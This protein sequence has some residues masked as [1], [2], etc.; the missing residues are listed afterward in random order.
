MNGDVEGYHGTAARGKKV[1]LIFESGQGVAVFLL[2]MLAGSVYGFRNCYERDNQSDD[3]R[4]YGVF[5]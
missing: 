4:I 3:V 2:R 5:N 1:S